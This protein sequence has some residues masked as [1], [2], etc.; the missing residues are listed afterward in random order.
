MK[1]AVVLTAIIGATFAFAD[2]AALYQKCV[3][4]HGAKGEKVALGKSKVINK[5]S[6]A[7][8]IAAMKGYKDG[9]YGGPMKAVMK[10]QV[11]AL[12]DAAIQAIT[13]YIVQ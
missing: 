11:V 2:A 3:A 1:K 12:D 9:S 4:C 13:D 10:G 6:K 7:D 5:M 8:F